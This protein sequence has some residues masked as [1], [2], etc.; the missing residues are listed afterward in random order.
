MVLMC[1]LSAE[2]FPLTCATTGVWFVD[3][4]WKW[5]CIPMWFCSWGDQCSLSHTGSI[6]AVTEV[7]QYTCHIRYIL[8][9]LGILSN[10][11]GLCPVFFC[12]ALLLAG[13]H[14][15]FVAINFSPL[16]ICTFSLHAAWGLLQMHCGHIA[17]CRWMSL[18]GSWTMKVFDFIFLHTHGMSW[19]LGSSS[20]PKYLKS[21]SKSIGWQR[22][23]KLSSSHLG[24]MK[25]CCFREGKLRKITML[26]FFFNIFIEA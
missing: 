14:F 6:T 21:A 7:Y 20:T 2:Q 10:F 22:W 16:S 4:C 9:S 17:S 12:L 25:Q 24:P 5:W 26:V 18:P 11:I 23:E 15:F 13:E 19:G 1:H 3:F 8:W